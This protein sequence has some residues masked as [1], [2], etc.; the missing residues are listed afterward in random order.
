MTYMHTNKTRKFGVGALIP[1]PKAVGLYLGLD[2]VLP[3]SLSSLLL[4]LQFSCSLI[5]KPISSRP[6]CA[7]LSTRLREIKKRVP[8]PRLLP[9]WVYV[10]KLGVNEKVQDTVETMPIFLRCGLN[11]F[12]FPAFF[13]HSSSPLIRVLHASRRAHIHLKT[14]KSPGNTLFK[15]MFCNIYIAW[16]LSHMPRL[17][18]A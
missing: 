17:R 9:C 13:F 12:F 4:A 15:Y 11:C 2:C 5:A 3:P 7:P 8:V 18:R 10:I 1:S 6:S 16:C 14:H